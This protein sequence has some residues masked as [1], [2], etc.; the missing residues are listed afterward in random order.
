MSDP[1]PQPANVTFHPLTPGRWADLEAVFGPNGATSGCWC[2]WFRQSSQEF[3]QCHGEQNRLA[4]RALVEG[5]TAPGLL[6][7]VEG[8]AAAWVAVEPRTAY[9]RLDRSRV[10]KPLDDEDAWAVTCFFIHRDFRGAGLQSQLLE[11]ALDW[12]KARGAKLIEGFPIDPEGRV[13]AASGF[14]GFRSTFTAAG[15]EEVARRTRGR[16]YMRKRL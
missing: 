13:A 15:F 4:L 3:E 1:S 5:G 16:P 12:A 11:A 14:Y 10:T 9:P 2:M 7:Y 6:A 8:R